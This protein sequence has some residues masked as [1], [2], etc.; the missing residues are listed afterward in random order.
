MKKIVLLFIAVLIVPVFTGCS[1]IK[2]IFKSNSLKGLIVYAGIEGDGKGTFIYAVSPDGKWKKRL[3]TGERSDN[4]PA[5][6][7]DGKSV[8]FSSADS[9]YKNRLYLM[10]ADGSKI[11]EIASTEYDAELASWS[12]DG[13]R[14]AF[15]E[16]GSENGNSIYI[17][18]S[19]GT[20][21]KKIASGCRHHDDYQYPPEWSVD[22]KYI[23]YNKINTDD[24]DGNMPECLYLL[25]TDGSGEKLL[26][27]NDNTRIDGCFSPDGKK[28]AYYMERKEIDYNRFDNSGIFVMNSDGNGETYLESGYKP[29]WSPDGTYIAFTAAN[30]NLSNCILLIYPDGT[31]PKSVQEEADADSEEYEDEEGYEEGGEEDDEAPYLQITFDGAYGVK[32]PVW[33]PDSK[34]IA[35]VTETSEVADGALWVADVS[36]N[37]QAAIAKMCWQVPPSWR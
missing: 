11:R 24:K 35:F 25:N 37:S 27:G 22:G 32:D 4:Y 15:L 34:K 8:V 17:I 30:L 29:V 12:P 13:Q 2:G 23:L 20:G 3:T 5:V 36:G 21:L 10:N 19:N 6:S 18:N 26:A 1:Q 9:K 33:S 28:V 16:R 7:P 14:I 31:S